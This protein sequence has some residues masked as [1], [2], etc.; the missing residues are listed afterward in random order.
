[1]STTVPA[2]RRPEERLKLERERSVFG[3]GDEQEVFGE[4]GEPVG[5]LAGGADRVAQLL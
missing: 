1:M 5:F 2:T 3:T 4:L